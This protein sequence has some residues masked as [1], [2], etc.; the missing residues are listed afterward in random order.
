MVHE[1]GPYIFVYMDPIYEITTELQYDTLPF[2]S[3]SSGPSGIRD[4][5]VNVVTDD[6]MVGI[7]TMSQEGT[8]D[9]QYIWRGAPGAPPPRR[10]SQWVGEVGWFIPPYHDTKNTLSGNQIQVRYHLKC[11]FDFI[12][13][14]Q[15]TV[16]LYS[17]TRLVGTFCKG[18][19]LIIQ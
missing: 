10:R 11:I 4:Y 19:M 5:K 2:S 7:G 8:S 15:C 9:L 17:F 12:C 1:E 6:R 3:F 14:V 13:Y 18:H 16:G